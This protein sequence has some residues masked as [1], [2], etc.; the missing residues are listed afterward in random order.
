MFFIKWLWTCI[1][2]LRFILHLQMIYCCKWFVLHSALLI[3]CQWI[4]D[5]QRKQ[6]IQCYLYVFMVIADMA[7][8]CNINWVI[9]EHLS[10]KCKLSVIW[11]VETA[12]IFLIFLIS[13][14][15]ISMEYEMQ[16]S[17]AWCTGKM[18]KTFEFMLT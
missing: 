11:F 10:W 12:S 14:V 1:Y 5:K 4:R 6:S 8:C 13:T 15:L 9:I 16:E 18:Y 2:S 3:Y 7:R 17:Y